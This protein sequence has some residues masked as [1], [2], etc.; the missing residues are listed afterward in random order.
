[1]LASVRWAASA[2]KRVI[3]QELA[4]RRLPAARRPRDEH[5]GRDLPPLLRAGQ[6]RR[7][8]AIICGVLI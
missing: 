6:Q 5:A 1:M 8:G 4:Q 2:S 7:D 3:A